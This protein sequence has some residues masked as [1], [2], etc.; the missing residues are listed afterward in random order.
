MEQRKIVLLD[1]DY[2]THEEKAVIRLFG[3][4][5]DENA[6]TGER[7]I[8]ALDDSF[9]PYI[10][11]IANDIKECQ[12]DLKNLDPEPAKVE[13]VEKKNFQIEGKFLKITFNHPQEVPQLR[14]AI[15]NF[16]S[17]DDIREHDIPFYRR[18]LINNDVFPMSEIELSGEIIDSFPTIKSKDPNL[19][20][21]KLKKPPVT[22]D[23]NFPELRIL[24][25]DLE[26]RNPDG[27]PNSEK[28]E[29]IMIGIS[30]NFDVEKVISTKGEDLDFVETVD[31]E[32]KMIESFIKTV[33]ENNADIIVGYNSDNF[34]FP[35]IKDRAAL[36]NIN[37]DLGMDGS[38]L[39]FLRRGYTN[40]ASLKGLLHIDLYLVMRRY[41]SLD[42][43]TLERVYFELFGEEKI[44]VPGD[45]IYQFWDNEG[46]ELDNLFDYSLD[47]VVSTLKLA[48]ETLPLSLE[49]T[50]IVGQPFF[51]ITR[52]ATGQQ[53]EWYLVRKANEY[54][55]LVPNKPSGIQTSSRKNESAVGGYVKEPEKG[56]HDNLVQFDF[57]SLYPSIIIS[58]NVSPD[59]LLKKH[60]G[61]DYNIVNL[62]NEEN[63]LEENDDNYNISPEHDNKFAKVPQGF[64]PSVIGNV[65]SERL[66]IKKQMKETED[67]TEKRILK[68]QQDALKRLANTMYGIYGFSR[69]RWYSM[70]CAES[71]TAWG[72]E[73]IKETMKKA[74]EYGFKSI[75]ADTDGFY[76]KYESN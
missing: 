28:D 71:I 66:K 21:L 69:F 4:E 53:A 74:E 15:N 34:D 25:F 17:V 49:L 32:K 57:R 30:S 48:E 67:P 23:S 12:E 35:Y 63:N 37:L 18:Y 44:E 38:S 62:L 61:T 36:Y 72:R 55:E 56:L 3:K 59:V 65:I 26:V 54:N 40:A 33:R 9:E 29:I 64:I 42:R 16:E 60:L 52:M 50:K 58:K 51:D 2:I 1:I 68:V 75:Y 7:K 11:V 14:D 8:I 19:E 6:K 10:Y 45:R 22:I 13:I 27:M 41:I 43:Y 24:S 76:A 39:K 47:D 20:I 73:Y 31:S 46:E 70:E 5:K